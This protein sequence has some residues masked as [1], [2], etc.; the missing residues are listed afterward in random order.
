MNYAGVDFTI[1]PVQPGSDVL[2]ALLGEMGFDSFVQHETGFEAYISEEDFNPDELQ[3]IGEFDFS[4]SYKIKT[5]EQKN[6]NEEWEKNFHP[7]LVEDKC[8][9]RASF[10]EPADVQ[11]D[12]IINPKMS[13]GTGH[14]DTTWMM[15]RTLFDLDL[16]GK[17]VLD[18]GCGT[19]VLAIIAHKLGAIKIEG[20]DIDDWSVENSIENASL[21]GITDIAFYKGNAASLEVKQ[22]DIILANINR[23]VL[24]ADMPAYFNCLPKAGKLLL[25]GFFDNDFEELNKKATFI[26]FSFVK[27]NVRNNWA[28]LEYQK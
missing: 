18:M 6:W 9:I 12:I 22:F 24:L 4:Y 17:T 16:K 20:I 27:K 26:G 14:H 8:C 7:V 13:F 11:L 28:Q 25:S 15:S 10:H 19:G 1:E 2:I 5:I 23:N 3:H 21:N